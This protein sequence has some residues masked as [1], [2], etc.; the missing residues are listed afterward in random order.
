MKPQVDPKEVEALLNA[1]PEKS[2]RKP[3]QAGK[4]IKLASGEPAA[5]SENPDTPFR[6]ERDTR[7]DSSVKSQDQLLNDTL[8]NNAQRK[9]FVVPTTDDRELFLRAVL[10][11]TALV[12]DVN[13]AVTDSV[14]VK[15]KCES[16]SNYAS[17][18]ILHVIKKQ[19]ESG[20]VS[21]FAVYASLL[22]QLSAA[23]QLKEF[24]SNKLNFF[25]CDPQEALESAAA[26][27]LEVVKT[28]ISPIHRAR[29]VVLTA[30]LATFEAKQAI[31]ATSLVNG[32]FSQPAS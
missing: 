20:A 28:K 23:I 2:K 8:R 30:A 25:T 11:D 32:D 27:L 31:M 15:V 13:V 17:D 21:E 16:R 14:S 5:P 3:K 7:F 24:N 9:E 4:T 18:L 26:R 1:K 19:V 12:L 29:W 6:A 10:M 22:Q